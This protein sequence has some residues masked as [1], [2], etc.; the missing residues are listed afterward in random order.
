MQKLILGLLTTTL[1]ACGS[2]GWGNGSNGGQGGDDN[3]WTGDLRVQSTSFLSSYNLCGNTNARVKQDLIGTG[4]ARLLTG[5]LSWRNTLSDGLGIAFNR[6]LIQNCGR[7]KKMLVTMYS[8]QPYLPEGDSVLYLEPVAQAAWHYSYGPQNNIYYEKLNSFIQAGRTRSGST[9]PL[10]LKKKSKD[11]TATSASVSAFLW[12]QDVDARGNTQGDLRL[13][14]IN[15]KL[16]ITTWRTDST[17]TYDRDIEIKIEQGGRTVG[18]GTLVF[19][20]QSYYNQNKTANK[21]Q[22][23]SLISKIKN[24]PFLIWGVLCGLILLMITALFLLPKKTKS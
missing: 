6:G 3:A 15:R 23:A 16:K 24:Q 1:M 9:P 13:S 20:D 21:R 18:T 4:I 7:M 5:S 14:S 12:N 22:L 19:D 11:T 17:S 8:Y 2:G 10:I